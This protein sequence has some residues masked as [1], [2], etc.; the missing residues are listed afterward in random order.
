MVDS[1]PGLALGV[2]AVLLLFAVIYIMMLIGEARTRHSQ[3]S[4]IHQA[5][6][7]CNNERLTLIALLTR[8]AEQADTDMDIRVAINEALEAPLGTSETNAQRLRRIDDS[9]RYLRERKADTTD[10]PG[11]RWVAA[12]TQRLGNKM[13]IYI[14]IED[15]PDLGA[16]E[17]GD[18]VEVLMRTKEVKA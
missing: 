2:L 9:C 12:P 17:P 1:L 14:P 13:C 10:A 4:K 5:Y 6:D 3:A 7:A 16:L 18:D 15:L 8:I 11:P